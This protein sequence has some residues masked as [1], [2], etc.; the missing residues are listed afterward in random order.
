MPLSGPLR[1]APDS[2]TSVLLAAG[3]LTVSI[4][5]LMMFPPDNWYG[6]ISPSVSQFVA[7]WTHAPTWNDGD[8]W[9]TNYLGHPIMGSLLYLFSRQTGH[10][11]L[12]AF[13]SATVASLVWEYALEGWF[14]QPSAPDLLV[15]STLGSVLGELRWRATR[16]LVA[17]GRPGITKQLALL[18]TDPIAE[19]RVLLALARG[20]ARAS[21][22]R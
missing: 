7:S 17:G 8:P 4:L 19:L 5:S 20:A 11:P 12:R 10:E 3:Y 6:Q 14:E 9:T 2:R 1:R 15:T 13:V 22:P 21:G 16:R 18:V